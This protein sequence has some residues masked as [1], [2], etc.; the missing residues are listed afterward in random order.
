MVDVTELQD[1]V[2]KL[3]DKSLLNRAVSGSFRN[4][5]ESQSTFTKKNTRFKKSTGLTLGALENEARGLSGS[6]F[7]DSA[8]VPYIEPLYF[9]WKRTAPIVPVNAKALSFVIGNRRVF[10]KS[11]KPASYK[12]NPFILDA[13]NKNRINLF[14]NYSDDLTEQIQDAIR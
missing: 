6:I 7:V 13:Y 5:L 3:Q 2:N 14:K 10:A 4:M 11:I 1:L 12:G 8:K 9:G